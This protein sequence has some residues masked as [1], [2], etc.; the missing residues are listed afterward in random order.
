M[1]TTLRYKEG[2]YRDFKLYMY[3]LQILPEGWDEIAQAEDQYAQRIKNFGA[4]GISVEHDFT[5]HT[6]CVPCH[7]PGVR[8]LD[9]HHVPYSRVVRKEAERRFG[10][11][12]PRCKQ[13][14]TD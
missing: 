4:V 7:D 14:A 12:G 3:D 5:D 9:E 11:Y 10:L 6:L 1:V 2:A 8:A 13:S